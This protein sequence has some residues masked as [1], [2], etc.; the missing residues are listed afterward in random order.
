M[1]EARR[2]Q[3]RRDVEP[4]FM[5]ATPLTRPAETGSQIDETLGGR[6]SMIFLTRLC[7]ALASEGERA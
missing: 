6:L 5:G 3:Q 2:R 1:T 4:A 7:E